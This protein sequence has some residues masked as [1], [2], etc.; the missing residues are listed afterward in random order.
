MMHTK[1]LP[2]IHKDMEYIHIA[3][4]P[5][6]QA[7]MLIASLSKK[8]LFTVQ[9]DDVMLHECIAYRTYETWFDSVTFEAHFQGQVM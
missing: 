7:R 4:L 1:V 6:D 9:L 5:P 3:Q 8:H 2:N